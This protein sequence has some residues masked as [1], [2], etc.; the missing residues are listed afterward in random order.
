MRT[1]LITYSFYYNDELI[2]KTSNVQL[3][4]KP[5]AQCSSGTD[6]EGLWDLI[7]KHP[8]AT[9]FQAW[10]SPKGECFLQRSTELFRK[11]TQKNIK[12][13]KLV[14][15][16]NE[17]SV[18]M[19]ELLEFNSDDVIEYLKERGMP[20]CSILNQAAKTK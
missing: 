8:F 20:V 14:I 3:L 13:W 10:K 12:P 6:F 4:S 11:T 18:S 19:K 5:L 7:H 15:S 16:S 9:P 17:T 2:R 1:Y